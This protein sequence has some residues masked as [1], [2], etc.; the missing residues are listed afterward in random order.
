M[1]CVA[2]RSQR[3][4]RR[5]DS[6]KHG[7]KLTSGGQ[8]GASGGSLPILQRPKLLTT[9][10]FIGFGAIHL[11]V[12]ATS[13]IDERRALGQPIAA[14]QPWIWEATSFLAWLLLLPVIL[15]VADRAS[16]LARPAF[17]LAI[18]LMAVV[19]VSLGHS[20]VLFAMRKLAYWS[21]AESY[22]RAG[23]IAEILF[24]EFRKDALTYA[25][26]V[27]A[28]L[29][30][31]RLASPPQ[32]AAPAEQEEAFIEVRDGSRSYWLRPD[33]VD[34]IA[35]AGNYVELNGDFGV[36]LARR[37]LAELEEQLLPLGFIRVHRSRL[38]RKAAIASIETRQSGDFDITLR[39]DQ[40]I[41]GSRRY[42]DHFKSGG[43]ASD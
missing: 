33:E 34:W 12:N 42:R 36:K 21:F 14:W 9:A 41:A 40:V 8:E 27:L 6:D 38:V 17:G 22:H 13:L 16:S 30:I 5:S 37:T 32:S 7:S 26:I 15:W 4:E 3:D 31:K 1:V 23:G 35:A 43:T 19:A 25:L 24:Y 28:F 2:A 18:H 11:V 20:A 39:S 29:L 10:A